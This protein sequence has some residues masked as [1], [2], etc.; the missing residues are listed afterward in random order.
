MHH[1]F[2]PD[3]PYEPSVE[4]YTG[5]LVVCGLALLV[6]MLITICGV[7]CGRKSDDDDKDA[8]KAHQIA[9]KI[10]KLQ[11]KQG[12]CYTNVDCLLEYYF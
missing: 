7:T 11:Q 6:C 2:S 8:A 3:S 9:K 10:H 12:C 4:Q 1:T 5:A